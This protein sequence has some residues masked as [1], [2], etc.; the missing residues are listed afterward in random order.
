M[1]TQKYLLYDIKNYDMSFSCQQKQQ[2][3]NFV[4]RLRVNQF[5]LPTILCFL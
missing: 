3:Q 1:L 2:Q 4:L 5:I